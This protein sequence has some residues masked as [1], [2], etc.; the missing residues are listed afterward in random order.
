MGIFGVALLPPHKG[1]EHSWSPTHQKHCGVQRGDAG[2]AQCASG[3]YQRLAL[4]PLAHGDPSG[5]TTTP[6]L[7]GHLR[8]TSPQRRAACAPQH[9]PSGREDTGGDYTQQGWEPAFLPPAQC[10][11][12]CRTLVFFCFFLFFFCFCF[13]NINNNNC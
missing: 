13:F 3:G 9:L 8:V 6:V 1:G 12:E 7:G 4:S 11:G 2:E 10:T 5:P